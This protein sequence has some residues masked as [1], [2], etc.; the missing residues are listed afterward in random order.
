MGKTIQFLPSERPG[1]LSHVGQIPE[2]TPPSRVQQR[3]EE[4]EDLTAFQQA[5]VEASTRRC[6][7]RVI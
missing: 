2:V 3:V 5:G 4:E 1:N 6:V 7:A